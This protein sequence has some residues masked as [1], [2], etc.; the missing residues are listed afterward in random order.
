MFPVLRQNVVPICNLIELIERLVSL[1]LN[2]PYVVPR[3]AHGGGSLLG[4]REELPVSLPERSPQQ[5]LPKVPS[6]RRR[7]TAAATVCAEKKYI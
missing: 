3:P 5:S 7:R 2:V 4:R 1:L 6:T